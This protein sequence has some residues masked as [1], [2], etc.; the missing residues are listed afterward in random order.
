M[1]KKAIHSL[2]PYNISLMDPW[3]KM[4]P[5]CPNQSYVTCHGII[6]DHNDDLYVLSE[7]ISDY[8]LTQSELNKYEFKK[9]ELRS[10]ELSRN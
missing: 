8:K 7:L 1:D 3:I 9:N 2:P 10:S 6:K 4:P 5:I